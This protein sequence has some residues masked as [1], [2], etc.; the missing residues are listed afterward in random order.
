MATPPTDQEKTL[1]QELKEVEDAIA[2]LKK[3][4]SDVGRKLR[5]LLKNRLKL[6]EAL[7]GLVIKK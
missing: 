2:V 6:L 1:R 7:A 4:I 3:E 5:D